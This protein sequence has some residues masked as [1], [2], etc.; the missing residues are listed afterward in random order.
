MKQSFVV[1]F[2]IVL[3]VFCFA[4]ETI[5]GSIMHDD[6]ER[7]YILYV[8]L[9]YTE[10]DTLPL[11][12]NF[13]GYGSSANEQMIYGDFR[14]LANSAGFFIVHPQGTLLQ[15]VTHWNVGGWTLDST[16]DDVGFTEALIDSLSYNFN[17]DPDRI[18]S[19][20]M[21]N[22]GFMSFLLA[23]QPSSRIAAIAS[24]TGSMTP[25]TYIDSN[26]QHP[27]PILQIHG[28]SDGL[29]LY[30][31][32][33]WSEPVEDVVQYWVDYN[34]CNPTPT[35]TLLPDLDPDDESTVELHIYNDGDSGVAVEHYKVFGGDHTWPGNVYGGAGTN[36][37][38]DASAEIWN[39]F[40]RYDINGLVNQ[41]GIENDNVQE[42]MNYRLNNYP[43][44]FNP[45][46]TISFSLKER[47]MVTVS[48]YNI[49]GQKVR[50]LESSEM[51]SG[52]HSLTWNGADD[53][54]S[55]VSSGI[56]FYKLD[57][58]SYSATK[59]MVMMK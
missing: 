45:T 11:V 56:Y 13:H 35:I 51:E 52:H 23:S 25:E 22:G 53:K 27:T 50:S 43:N 46:T 58:D 26:P 44:P 36:N 37:D 33:D 47:E 18:Y 54:G 20:G 1:I 59:K 15:G 24:V 38:I 21:S 55:V 48:I 57:T 19:T 2:L 30:N 32:T 49:Q 41:V 3:S 6:I 14:S 31:G 42:T 34:N 39:F 28:T 5:H 17:I 40:S 7:D 12:L 16:V 29:V 8:P 10:N 4:Q 9:S